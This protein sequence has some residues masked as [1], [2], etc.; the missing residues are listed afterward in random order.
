MNGRVVGKLFWQPVP[1]AAASQPKDYRVKDGTLVH[2]RASGS[3]RWIMLGKDR[4]DLLPQLIR[5]TPNRG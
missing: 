3:L 2:P 1:L 4:L 5:H